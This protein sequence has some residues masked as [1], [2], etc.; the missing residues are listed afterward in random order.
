MKGGLDVFNLHWKEAEKR[1]GIWGVRDYY[2]LLEQMAREGAEITSG[3][4]LM[5]LAQAHSTLRPEEAIPAGI[6]WT[7]KN[8]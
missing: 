3:Y 1:F 8:R 5:I 7:R 6:H 2:T 4:I